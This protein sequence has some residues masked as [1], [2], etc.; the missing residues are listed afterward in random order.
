MARLVIVLLGIA[1]LGWGQSFTFT[2]ANPVAAQDFHFKAAAFVFRTEGCPEPEKPQLSGT[3][4]GL[5][6]GER[7]S[8]AVK[9]IPTS[10]PGVYAITQSWPDEGKWVVNLKGT[11]GSQ[12]AGALVPMGPKGFIRESAKLFPRPATS[13]EVDAS[14]KALTQGGK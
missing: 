4:E 11:C 5:V 9:V 10:K 12:T 13:G 3:A 6:A 1:A 2:L 14:L 8:A 7:R